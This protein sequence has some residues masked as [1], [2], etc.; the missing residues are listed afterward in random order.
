MAAESDVNEEPVS[1]NTQ[2]GTKENVQTTAKNQDIFEGGLHTGLDQSLTGLEGDFSA[3][4]IDSPQSE[5]E[6]DVNEHSLSIN[7]QLMKK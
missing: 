4:K 6:S 3:E 7:T 2:S 1:T 5:A